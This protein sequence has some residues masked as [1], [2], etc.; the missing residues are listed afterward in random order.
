MTGAMRTMRL[1]VSAFVAAAS[2]IAVAVP[3]PAGAYARGGAFTLVSSTPAG[4]PGNNDSG[5]RPAGGPGVAM[6][7]DGRYI[8]FASAASDLVPG[9]TNLLPDVFV[10]DRKTGRTAMA[11][12]PTVG[13]VVKI[14]IGP[15]ECDG[16]DSPAI[17]DD[18]RY[19][20]FES[21]DINLIGVGKDTNAGNDIFVHDMKTGTTVRASVTSTGAE[22]S[23]GAG[24]WVPSISA[25]GRP[26][27][28]DGTVCE[29][30]GAVGSTL[31]QVYVHDMHTGSTKL[32][33]ATANGQV[34]NG[35]S[36]AAKVSPDGRYVAFVSAG[37]NLVGNDANLSPTDLAAVPSAPDVFVR[38]MKT[39][40]IRL[41]SVSVTGRS[42]SGGPFP[43]SG[44]RTPEGAGTLAWSGDDRYLAFSSS[45][46]DLV[47]N[48]FGGGIFVRD[49]VQNRTERV[50]VNSAGEA[51]NGTQTNGCGV[52]F[53]VGMSRNG[54]YVSFACD[55]DPNCTYP[56]NWAAVYDRETGAVD[57]VS[58]HD[59]Q[60]KPTE[61]CP[62][63]SD[64]TASDFNVHVSTDGRFVAFVSQRYLGVG[65]VPKTAT[66]AVDQ[67]F[68]RDRGAAVGVGAVGVPSAVSIAN[69]RAFTTSGV[70]TSY[71]A[72]YD[73]DGSWQLQGAD[74]IG[75][76]LAYRP[77]RRD[78]FV[79]LQVSQMPPVALANPALIYGLSF[80]ANG[81]HYE[82]RAGKSGQ[83]A[84]CALYR[85]TAAG[86]QR[87]AALAGGYGT[88]GAEVTA[89]VPIEDLGGDGTARLRDVRA[90]TALGALAP[91]V[92]TPLDQ[93][94]LA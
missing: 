34:S 59:N 9:D 24:S 39:G 6:T 11:S 91:G 47:P 46:Y 3:A 81:V 2:A 8:A 74:L 66:G 30:I 65:G 90:F 83:A 14:G 88:T 25:D 89:A 37:N 33:S 94:A 38:D 41:V 56:Y 53:D 57:P 29:F 12:V 60:G 76:T 62:A 63:N 72:A 32:V 45:A 10:R 50:S 22:S 31:T 92:E 13:S 51:Y 77:S 43:D 23:P 20:A 52:G 82:L 40:A 87:I 18:G 58:G 70:V 17:S 28:T 79:R 67:V 75:A 27:G 69:D 55:P 5:W 36:W 86:W 54:R 73:V 71:D 80:S 85:A 84:S 15:P 48:G 42:A 16:S 78:L 7:P 68:V 19:V 93:L 21:C 26:T 35:G 1:A 44:A 61:Q 49:L 64:G 4:K